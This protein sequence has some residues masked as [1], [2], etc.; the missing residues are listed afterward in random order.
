MKKAYSI[1]INKLFQSRWLPLL[2]AVSFVFMPN[3]LLIVKVLG[4]LLALCLFYYSIV[5]NH[6]VPNKDLLK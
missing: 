5:S 3:S 4:G 1:F 2:V 6:N